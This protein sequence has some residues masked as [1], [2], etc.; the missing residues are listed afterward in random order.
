MPAPS[1][2]AV[3][4][5]HLESATSLYVQRERLTGAPHVKLLQLARHDE[6]I[7]AHLDGLLIASRNGARV[8]DAA[9]AESPVGGAFVAGAIALETRDTDAVGPLL[10]A[11]QS[12][13]AAEGGLLRAFGWVAATCLKGIAADL[14]SS[15]D[16]FRRRFGVAVCG[17]HRVDPGPR[18]AQFLTDADPGVRAA[19]WRLAGELGRHELV[20]TAAASAAQEVDPECRFW[21]AWA[22]LLLGDKQQALG[23]I[24]QLAELPGRLGQAAFRLALQVRS[25]DES[26]PL[27]QA[28][29]QDSGNSRRLIRG[30]GLAGD[31]GY[32]PWLLSRME[33]DKLARLAGESFSLITGADLAWLDLERKPPENFESGPNDDPND[34]NVDLDE[35]DG[36]PWPDPERVQAWWSANS[37]RF[38][39]GTRYFMGEP[40]NRENCLRVLK[41]GYQRQRIAAAIYLALL[42]PGTPLFEWRAPASRQQ[43]ALA[44]MV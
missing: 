39:P 16:A 26:R 30:A 18:R 37:Q 10:A 21:A 28:L 31:P 35:D 36:L 12:S 38:Q 40:V 27:L 13:A 9:L 19:A 14:L 43:R 32:V 33:D 1:I 3:V 22:G 15:H 34:A 42:N 6:R 4:T 23:V 2:N 17:M 25:P 24:V 44:Q 7:A 11:A 8:C 41:D 5:Q 29:V 20:S